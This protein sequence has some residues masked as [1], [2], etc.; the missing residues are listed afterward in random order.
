[1]ALLEERRRAGDR[2][3]GLAA[4]RP[5]AGPVPFGR[6]ERFLWGEGEDVVLGDQACQIVGPDDPSR[7]RRGRRH[8]E[9][10]GQPLSAGARVGPRVGE[11]EALPCLGDRPCKEAARQEQTVLGGGQTDA[12]GDR[13]A[14]FVVE[15]RELPAATRCGR[16]GRDAAQALALGVEEQRV[17]PQHTGES[18]LHEPEDRRETKGDAGQRVERADVD[19][20]TGEWLR[21]HSLPLEARN[22]DRL[23]I[24][25]LRPGGDA[26][27]VGKVRRARARTASRSPTSPGVARVHSASARSSRADHSSQEALPD[28][29]ANGLREGRHQAKERPRVLRT[30]AMG[31]ASLPVRLARGQAL[32]LRG[33]GGGAGLPAIEPGD[34][35]GL[36]A[37]QVP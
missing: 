10:R 17:G 26:A 30:S 29:S 33:Q 2:F 13:R 7:S 35:P 5:R 16:G 27:Q 18:A 9:Q 15:Q 19:A 25:P 28:S 4:P 22:D 37:E 12:G 1:M 32:F 20:P 34:D 36:S 3:Q 14:L 31:I 11:Q 24:V 21:R 6:V 8:E 23:H